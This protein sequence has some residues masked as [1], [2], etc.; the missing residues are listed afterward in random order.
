MDGYDNFGAIASIARVLVV[1]ACRLDG[2]DN[3]AAETVV[4]DILVVVEACRLDGYDNFL[5]QSYHK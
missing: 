2:Y 1:E 4:S 3:V 5:T